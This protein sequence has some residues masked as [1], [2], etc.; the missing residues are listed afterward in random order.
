MACL[1]GGQHLRPEF[2]NTQL[3]R[4]ILRGAR[5]IPG[6]HDDALDAALF[7]FADDVLCFRT[8]RI[9]DTEN[10]D[11]LAALSHVE[12]RL[13]FSGQTLHVRQPRRHIHLLVFFHEVTRT[14]DDLLTV[15]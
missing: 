15:H 12:H 7:E 5:V 14:D 6:E 3:T 2:R 10:A 11:Q 9:D 8:Q 13:P 4:H 1:I